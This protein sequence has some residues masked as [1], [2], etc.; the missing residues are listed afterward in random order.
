MS[1]A[2]QLGDRVKQQGAGGSIQSDI[3]CADGCKRP[4]RDI[5][6]PLVLDLESVKASSQAGRMVIG[7]DLSRKAPRPYRVGDRII[8]ATIERPKFIGGNRCAELD[9]KLRNGLADIAIFVHHLTDRESLPEQFGTVNGSSAGDFRRGT[10]G[11]GRSVFA[12]DVSP[13][14]LAAQHLDELL[15]KQRYAV[16]DGWR[17]L[18]GLESLCHRLPATFDQFFA[19]GSD[20]FME[21]AAT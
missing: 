2:L 17:D 1:K 8:Q 9:G 13:N 14:L 3:P 12:D 19:I 18:G 16:I 6:P 15:Q 10:Y 20:E 5:S 7:H 11:A 21:H 4:Q